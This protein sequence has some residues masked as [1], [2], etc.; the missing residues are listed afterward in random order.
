VRSLEPVR[1]YG[2]LA[3]GEDKTTSEIRVIAPYM[4]ES[5]ILILI[6]LLKFSRYHALAGPIGMAMAE[7]Y[8]AMGRRDG[9]HA[10]VVAVP[11]SRGERRRRGPD[12]TRWLATAFSR[13]LGATV[14]PDALVKTR[15]TKR[16]SQ[17]PSERRAGNV[18]GA[19]ACRPGS[20][21]GRHVILLD[22]LVTT[23]ATAAACVAE[24]IAAGASDV[25]VA[26]FARAL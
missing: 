12:A 21:A 26:C 9:A 23:G 14:N 19:F 17:T 22:D 16:Q 15:T 24:L 20:V 18:R 3:L 2:R 1:S 25:E 10:V 4:I 6:H 13:A 8:H 7:A 5:N 11:R